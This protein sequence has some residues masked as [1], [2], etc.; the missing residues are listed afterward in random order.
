MCIPDIFCFVNIWLSG[1]T[2][3]AFYGEI[4]NMCTREN[5]WGLIF[6]KDSVFCNLIPKFN[7]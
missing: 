7:E 1:L 4:S 6:T 5:G 3:I 2:T